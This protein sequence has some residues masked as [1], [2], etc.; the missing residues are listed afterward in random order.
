MAVELSTFMASTMEL[1]MVMSAFD[2]NSNGD[3]TIG[4]FLKTETTC[5]NWK[6]TSM[7]TWLIGINDNSPEK[8]S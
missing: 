2:R 1:K 6:K 8:H 3:G 5:F 7:I 4:I